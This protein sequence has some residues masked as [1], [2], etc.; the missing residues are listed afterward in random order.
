MSAAEQA[1]MQ[2]AKDDAERERQRVRLYAPPPAVVR[3]RRSARGGPGG[4]PV[5]VSRGDAQALMA[6]LAAEDTRYGGS[7]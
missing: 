4:A 5:G 6:R 1:M 2:A 7:T 3:G